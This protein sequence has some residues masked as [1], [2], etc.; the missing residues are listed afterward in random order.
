[1]SKQ[2]NI[3][4]VS[5]E[6]E[7]RGDGVIIEINTFRKMLAEDVFFADEDVFWK[8]VKDGRETSASWEN[9]NEIPIDE[10][11]HVVRYVIKKKG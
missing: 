10:A 7:L 1:M 9:P 8:P 11:D 3:Q 4:A 2:D 6:H 5:F